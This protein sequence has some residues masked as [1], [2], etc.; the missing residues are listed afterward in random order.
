MIAIWL[1]PVFYAWSFVAN[2]LPR[3][4]FV[5]YEINP[6]TAAVELAHQGFWVPTA[7]GTE[8]EPQILAMPTDFT[9]TLG[10]AILVSLVFVVAGQGI[11]RRWQGHFGE[12]I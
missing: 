6:L 1:S 11:F 12:E 10:G 4:A 3:W 2:A 5:I 8:V 9:M 7:R